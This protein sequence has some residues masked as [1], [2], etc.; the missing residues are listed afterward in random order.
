MAK[1]PNFC[2]VAHKPVTT[3]RQMLR[4]VKDSHEP[5][6]R[7]ET[8][9]KIK[10]CDCQATYIGETGI[11]LN[12]RLTEYKRVTR[13]GDIN[14]HIAEHHLHTIYRIDWDCY[15]RGTYS[16]DYYQRTTQESWCTNLEQTLLN[17]F[18]K[19]YAN[20]LLTIPTRQTNNRPT[21]FTNDRPTDI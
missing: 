5:S 15:K 2:C 3:L 7:Q 9:Y 18:Q 1:Q 21:N 4:N 19:P 11:N 8:V 16:T 20:D 12:I 10:C 13:N 14:N 17:C 6:D